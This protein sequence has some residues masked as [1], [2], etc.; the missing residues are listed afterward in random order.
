MN[1][2]AADSFWAFEA[3]LFELFNSGGTRDV[4]GPD[5]RETT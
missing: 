2:A 5:S 3:I 1:S 4:G